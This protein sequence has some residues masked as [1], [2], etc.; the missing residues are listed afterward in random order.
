M[1]CSSFSDS[2]GS[3]FAFLARSLDAIE[4]ETPVAYRAMCDALGARVL[5]IEADGRAMGLGA[6]TGRAVLSHRPDSCDVY[7]RADRPTVL[8][9]IEGDCSIVEAAL[10]GDLILRGAA[11]D[12]AAFGDALTAFVQGAVR[13]VS[14]PSLLHAYKTPPD[15]LRPYSRPMDTSQAGEMHD[16]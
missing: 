14:A 11:E 8:R 13:S 2:D 5:E 7:V 16:E 1:E 9:L 3:F 12:L 4:R 15:S 10:L 6:T